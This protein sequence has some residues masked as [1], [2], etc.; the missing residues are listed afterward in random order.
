M[1]VNVCTDFKANPGDTVNF[2]TPGST[3]CTLTK[4]ASS[5]WPFTDGSPLQVPVAGKATSVKKTL[6]AGIY[7]YDV[8]CC[9]PAA[10]AK[11][12]TVS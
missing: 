7:S 11:T 4:L 1:K 3:A 9:G 10:I 5:V 2:T 8:D 6:T 12:V